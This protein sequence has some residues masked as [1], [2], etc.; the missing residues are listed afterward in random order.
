[1]AGVVNALTQS[2]GHRE[3]CPSWSPPAE[4]DVEAETYGQWK[5]RMNFWIQG[6]IQTQSPYAA[7]V[8]GVWAAI[9]GTVARTLASWSAHAWFLWR[10]ELKN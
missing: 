1:M 6:E 9:A 10:K 3:P 2:L 5:K 7:I 8:K 4:G